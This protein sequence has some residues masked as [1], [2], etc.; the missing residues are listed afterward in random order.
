VGTVIDIP[1]GFAQEWLAWHDKQKSERE[2]DFR[3]SQIY[4]TRCA[5]IAATVVATAGAI[6]WMVTIWLAGFQK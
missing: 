2:T 3:E 1:K 6:G 5:A 4:W